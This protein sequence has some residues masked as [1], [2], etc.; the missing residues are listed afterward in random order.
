MVQVNDSNRCIEFPYK[1]VQQWMNTTK[2]Q[3]YYLN[4]RNT[5]S[6]LEFE[7]IAQDIIQK[8]TNF[9]QNVDITRMFNEIFKPKVDDEFELTQINYFSTF[10]MMKTLIL[11]EKQQMFDLSKVAILNDSM[12][13]FIVTD[14][15][16]KIEYKLNENI[17]TD[18]LC[19]YN[20]DDTLSNHKKYYSDSLPEEFTLNIE[21]FSLILK[22]DIKMID[23]SDTIY[24]ALCSWTDEKKFMLIKVITDSKLE[25][26]IDTDVLFKDLF[27]EGTMMISCYACSM[28]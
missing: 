6:K 5:G 7:Y 4:L 12:K 24:Y 26:E 19:D 17:D 27:V 10:N 25:S 15:S 14:S 13:K 9:E 16:I 28:I 21:N 3:T 11:I 8:A 23:C 1:T 2:S 22:S 18:T 20:K